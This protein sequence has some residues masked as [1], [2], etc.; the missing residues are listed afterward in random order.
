MTFLGGIETGGTK[1][2]CMIAE[3]PSNIAAQTQFDT[4]EPDVTVEKIVA[5]FRENQKRLGIQ[6]P[7]VG[8]ASFGPI[9]LHPA[10]PQYGFVTS[11]P[12]PGWRDFDL[13]GSIQQSLDIPMMFD[14]D[15]NGAALGEYEW[16]AGRGLDQFIYLTIGTGIGG[17]ALI[18]GKPVHGL[19][20]PEM[21]HI[22]LPHD[23]E[24]DPFEGACPFHGDCFEG[25]ASGPAIEK[26]WGI[27]GHQLP[28][29]HPAWDIEAQ[30]LASGLH[31]LI[32]SFS[33]QR[34]ILGGGVMKKPGLLENVRSKVTESLADYIDSDTIRNDM[35][36]YI[37]AP[38]LG[39]NAGV[40]G[41]IVMAKR[42]IEI[43]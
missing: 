4:E 5:F 43:S 16:G 35:Q 41:A 37:V 36:E 39:D 28:P 2:V 30:H 25:L 22:L 18:G 23:R 8:L 12:K 1:C 15:T 19:V 6:L 27:P 29:E 26:R 40:L 33:P 24:K 32:C 38:E 17:G 11:T 42:L 3:N 7:A 31:C 20:H 14:T 34:L 9:D 21:G 10:S 13:L